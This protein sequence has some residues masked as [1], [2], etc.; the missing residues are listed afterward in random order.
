MAHS[1]ILVNQWRSEPSSRDQLGHHLAF[2]KSAQEPKILCKD[3]VPRAE[4]YA[5]TMVEARAVQR[6][7]PMEVTPR[8][9]RE[10]Q[11]VA[12]VMAHGQLNDAERTFRLDRIRE[13]WLA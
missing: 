5:T 2:I 4:P 3:A 9:M 1:K 7:G 12:S 13:C 6:S 10:V 11:G 8:L